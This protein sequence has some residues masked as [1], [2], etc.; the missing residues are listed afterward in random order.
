MDTKLGKVLTCSE[1]LLII[2]PYVLGSRNQREVT[3]QFSKFIFPLSQCLQEEVE[4]ENAQVVTNPWF[5]KV[6]PQKA[7]QC[8][9]Y[10]E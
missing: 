1:R 5:K 2:K 9:Q 6:C 7:H 4:R 3:Y 10:L 8:P